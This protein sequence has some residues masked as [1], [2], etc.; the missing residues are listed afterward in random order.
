MS[1]Q[2]AILLAL[3]EGGGG[4]PAD[5]SLMSRGRLFSCD[6]AEG[7]FLALQALSIPVAPFLTL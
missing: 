6:A 2:V 1:D 5:H 3:S 4:I 7:S